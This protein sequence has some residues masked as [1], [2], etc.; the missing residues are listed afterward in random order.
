MVMTRMYLNFM[1]LRMLEDFVTSVTINAN[2]RTD[3]EKECNFKTLK[4]C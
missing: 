2:K 4:L 1:F 3:S